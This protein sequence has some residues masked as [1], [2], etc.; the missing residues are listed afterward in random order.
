MKWKKSSLLVLLGLA[1]LWV[2][3]HAARRTHR[4]QQQQPGSTGPT[5][6]PAPASGGWGWGWGGPGAGLQEVTVT[7]EGTPA[8]FAVQGDRSDAAEAAS[9]LAELRARLRRLATEGGSDPRILRLRER[10]DGRLGETG[11]GDTDIAYSSQKRSVRI[12]LR[13]PDGS[14]EQDINQLMFVLVH[15]AAH[16]TCTEV[17]HTDLYWRIFKFLLEKA[18]SL[19]I[20]T[21]SDT[22]AATMCGTR[23]GHNP[24]TCVREGTCESSMD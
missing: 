14:L 3:L 11:R 16:I 12:C 18:E 7:H 9:L 5:A 6:T 22:T 2:I 23:L 1:A 4:Q 20:Y 15:E 17:G 8:P 13:K 10:W 24:I 21:Y 19:G